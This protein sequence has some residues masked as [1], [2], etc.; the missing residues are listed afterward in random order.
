L[1]EGVGGALEGIFGK[2]KSKKKAPE[3]PEE[4]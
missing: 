3:S 4:K 1:N 2:K